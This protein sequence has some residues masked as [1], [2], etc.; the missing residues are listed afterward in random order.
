G[1]MAKKGL[2]KVAKKREEG[3][4]SS[5]AGFGDLMGAGEGED[6]AAGTDPMMMMIM[7]KEL[8]RVSPGFAMSFGVSMALAGGAIVSKGSARQIREYAI[9]IMALEKIGAWCLTEP[10]A[11]SDAFGMMETTVSRDGDGYI[12]NGQKT[13]ITNGPVA[14]TFVV[15]AKL[16]DGKTPEKDRQVLTFIVEKGME[17]FTIGEPFDK[18]GMRESRTSEIFFN[19][20]KLEK[21]NLMGET[22]G[23]GG[24]KATKD[25]LGNERSGVPGM[26]WGI[27]ERCYDEVVEL[28]KELEENG[29]PMAESQSIQMQIYE[30]YMD[31]KNVEGLVFRTIWQQSNGIR[32]ITFINAAKAYASQTA[33]KVAN[34]ALQLFGEYGTKRKFAFEKMFRDCKLLELGAGTTVINMLTAARNELGL[35]KR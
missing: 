31:L 26:C 2:E 18:M 15:Y 20:V 16:D 13:F 5:G 19:N 14:D 34:N 1:A 11:G 3:E 21:K 10:G 22:E 4:G 35:I 12:M 29:I 17:G 7:M 23:E 32:D 8:C 33:V 27:I 30:M 24:R 9:P 25:S 6:G 28:A